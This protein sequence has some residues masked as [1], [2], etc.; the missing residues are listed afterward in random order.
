[1]AVFGEALPTPANPSLP[2]VPGAPRL[3]QASGTLLREIRILDEYGDQRPIFIPSERP[4]TVFVDK[5]ELV[6]LMTLGAIPELLVL[7]YLR[8]Q[9]LIDRVDQIESI[10]V[11]WDVAA[12]AVRTRGGLP[13]LEIAHRRAAS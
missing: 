3:T 13:D 2:V 8:N 6:T 12:A 10:T 1:M 4:L 5:R 9:R 11:D 7:G